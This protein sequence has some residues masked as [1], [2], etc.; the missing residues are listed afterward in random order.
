MYCVRVCTCVGHRGLPR[1][2]A[3]THHAGLQRW[4]RGVV[5]RELQPHA[6]ALPIAVLVRVPRPASRPSRCGAA[7]CVWDP[8]GSASAPTTH[9]VLGA[10]RWSEHGTPAP[11]THV[12]SPP[13]LY[14][15]HSSVPATRRTPPRPHPPKASLWSQSS[16]VGMRARAINI[17]V[18]CA[19]SWTCTPAVTTPCHP[20]RSVVLV[21]NPRRA[22][23]HRHYLGTQ[24]RAAVQPTAED[25][26]LQRL[27]RAPRF[28][29]RSTPHLVGQ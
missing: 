11:L 8:I 24:L 18:S 10:P 23:K 3:W 26:C 7:R 20:E 16:A 1:Y 19:S 22:A 25:Y 13:P 17:A 15:A 21:Q 14:T 9:R 29:A 2:R 5:N 27:G 6:V 28:G 12:G 4:R